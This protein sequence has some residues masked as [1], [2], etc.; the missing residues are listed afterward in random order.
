MAKFLYSVRDHSGE[1]LTGTLEARNRHEALR[2]LAERHSL[3][4]RLEVVREGRGMW[5]W[6]T[7]QSVSNQELLAFTHQ[8]AA[9]LQAGLSFLGAMEILLRDRV[10]RPAMR[11]VLVKVAA[12]VHEGKSLAQALSEHPRVF[13]PLYVAMVEAGEASAS[14]PAALRRL[15]SYTER[16]A[17]MQMEIAGALSYPFVVLVVGMVLA[18]ALVMYA[19]PML[20]EMYR[21]VGAPLPWLSQM[22]L[23]SI[24]FLA[25]SGLLVALGVFL[26]GLG[27][28]RSSKK[29]EWVGALFDKILVNVGPTKEI[30]QEALM[31][32]CS[33]TLATLYSSA[34]PLLHSLEMTAA[35]AGN[36]EYKKLFLRVRDSMGAGLTLSDALLAE[37]LVPSMAA[38]M[39]AAGEASGSLSDLLDSTAAY[40]E[41]RVEVALQ[42]FTRLIEPVLILGVG[43][44][45]GTLVLALGLPFLNL[46][47]ALC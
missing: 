41:T 4:V 22:I 30:V 14:L 3:V 24:R 26:A 15:A 20:E 16:V 13:S 43:G 36:R 32:R 7:R 27:V 45:I 34:V 10:H 19:V 33:R 40:Y 8:L 6:L 5:Q 18:M 2:W 42:A 47:S 17:R 31:A 23:T 29:M 12:S 38:G 1:L 21:A 35:A 44:V 28:A 11:Q 46:V 25:G 9:M 39:V 37:P